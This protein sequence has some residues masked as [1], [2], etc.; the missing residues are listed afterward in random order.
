MMQGIQTFIDET[1]AHRLKDTEFIF[2][3]VVGTVAFPLGKKATDAQSHRW[4]VYL[5]GVNN[6]DLSHAISR[7]QFDLHPTF[8]NANRVVERQPFEVTEHGWGE[9][10][11][12][13]HINFA[14]DSGENE[15]VMYHRLRL[16]EDGEQVGSKQD[17][18]KAVVS[19]T[20][21]ELVF[22]EPRLEFYNRMRQHMPVPLNPPS[23]LLPYFKPPMEQQELENIRAMRARVANLM[24][25]LRREL[26]AT[27]PMQGGPGGTPA[28]PPP[29]LQSMGMPGI[30]GMGMPGMQPGLMPGMQPGT[31]P[32]MAH[33]GH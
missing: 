33:M 28:P 14:T 27:L 10:E 9:F 7:V 23:Q 2:P 15:A 8:V 4:T 24:A 31:H 11:I 30:A 1:G 6:E 17:P 18:K 12:V 29:A 21:E 5:R 32:G 26:G 19:E 13:V 25:E 22:S 20:Y 16:Y 3:V